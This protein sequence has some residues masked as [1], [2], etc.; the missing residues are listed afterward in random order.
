[1]RLDDW[2]SQHNVMWRPTPGTGGTQE[3]EEAEDGKFKV[4]VSYIACSRLELRDCFSEPEHSLFVVFHDYG[5]VLAGPC[6][7]WSGRKLLRKSTVCL[8]FGSPFLFPPKV[9]NCL[10]DPHGR[11]RCLS[12]LVLLGDVVMNFTNPHS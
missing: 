8:L 7:R 5:K 10:Q 6:S 12:G 2:V 1:M 3:E 4:T 9:Q 11:G